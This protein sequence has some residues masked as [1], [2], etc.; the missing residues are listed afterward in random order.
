MAKTSGFLAML[1]TISG[2]R[3][4]PADRP[5]NTSAPL[6]SAARSPFRRSRFVTPAISSIARFIPSF[7]PS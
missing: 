2:F 5:T 4:P 3:M 1:R 6:T 7:L